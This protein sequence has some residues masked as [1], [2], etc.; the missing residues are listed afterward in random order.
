MQSW[1][2]IQTAYHVARVGTVSG[3]AEALG[4]HHATV[5][6]HVDALETRLGTK[7]F[8][9]HPRGYSTTEAG[10]LLLKVAQTTA[11]QFSH[12]TERITGA[13]ND[14]SGELI[15]T[16]LPGLAQLVVATL[17]RLKVAHPG[18]RVRYVSDPRLFRLEFG[19]AHVAIR[20]GGKP[21]EPD[22]VVQRFCSFPNALYASRGYIERHGMPAR[23][24]I[25]SLARHTFVGPV[26][27]ES[28]APFYRWLA[29]HIA[30]DSIAFRTN[31][32]EAVLE[33]VSQGVAL[34]FL[35][36]FM[37]RGRDDLVQV[38]PPQPDWETPL[39][40][41]THVDLHRTRRVQLFLKA[42]KEDARQRGAE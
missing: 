16:S 14:I 24:D 23:D 13:S 25:A 28:P 8:Q 27:V 26:D 5:I 12:L 40:L 18:L 42:V 6:R 34:G 7:L 29:K 31:E 19:E 15:V 2:E 41:V 32:R 20:A 38:M 4:I 10:E 11:D 3:A 33:A 37:L 9:R 36:P 35:T 30:P 17:A 1:D 22:N 39:W 21:Q